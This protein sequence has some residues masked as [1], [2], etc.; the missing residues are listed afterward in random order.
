MALNYW[1]MMFKQQ[2]HTVH[3][4]K[5]LI[6][7]ITA[8]SN[9]AYAN[10]DIDFATEKNKSS[11]VLTADQVNTS[12]SSFKMNGFVSQGF[13]YSTDNNIYGES[14]KGTFEFTEIGL[15]AS[16]KYTPRLRGSA[17]VIV[18]NAGHREET[19]ID[20]D[21][22]FLSYQM[23]TSSSSFIG[24][25]VGRVKNVMGFYNETRDVSFTRPSIFAPQFIYFDSVRDLQLSSDGLIGFAEWNT[26]AGIFSIDLGSGLSRIDGD[27]EAGLIGNNYNGRF[28][29]QHINQAQINYLHT[30]SNL[31]FA[32]SKVKSDL[33]HNSESDSPFDSA[34]VLIDLDIFSTEYSAEAFSLTAELMLLRIE[35]NLPPIIDEARFSTSWY[36]QGQYFIDPDWTLYSR[37][38]NYFINKND[39]SGILYSQFSGLPNHIAYAKNLLIGTK[40]H[41]S[42]QWMLML[43]V[44]STLGTAG[45]SRNENDLR[46]TKRNWQ[47]FSAMISYRF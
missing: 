17:Q 19:G 43:E 34:Q 31:R 47:M 38:E 22:A 27:T 8:L 23:P 42:P 3:L 16:K 24:A 14:E 4:K 35:F 37:Y 2:F 1:H 5:Y 6:L 29:R 33:Q 36:M 10:S 13:L 28:S 12:S 25:R 39:K 44:Q 18:R 20:L 21:Y 7:F 32:Y 9:I 45:L 26:D 40:W 30:D 46:E 15:N 41:F 11:G